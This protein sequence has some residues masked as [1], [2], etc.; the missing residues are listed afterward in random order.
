[1]QQTVPPGDRGNENQATKVECV[2]TSLKPETPRKVRA[3]FHIQSEV[4][5]DLR[6]AAYWARLTLTEI[7]GHA[8]R[9]ELE[10]LQNEHNEGRPFEPRPKRAA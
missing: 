5:E 2:V 9:K 4:L 3:T 7:A 1:M 10:R 6:D 8:F